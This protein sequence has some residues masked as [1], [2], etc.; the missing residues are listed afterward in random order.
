MIPWEIQI[1]VY[2]KYYFTCIYCG[3]DG[4]PFD[5]WLQM[6]ID[7]ILPE[8]CVG[9]DEENNLVPSCR[10]CNSFTSR[11]VFNKD[12]DKEDIIRLKRNKIS[13]YRIENFETW[14]KYVIPHIMTTALIKYKENS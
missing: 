2:K 3:F 5:N 9:D 8:S 4:R 7:H 1:R 6:S 13:Q 14:E 11:M 10:A 12:Q